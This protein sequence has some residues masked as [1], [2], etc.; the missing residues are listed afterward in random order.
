MEE[1]SVNFQNTFVMDD[2]R[3]TLSSSKGQRSGD[4]IATY[5][6]WVRNHQIDAQFDAKRLWEILWDGVKPETREYL[7]RM[8]SDYSKFKGP[9]SEAACYTEM[10][11]AGK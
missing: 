4:K 3:T 7:R 1:L 9:L 6:T 11:E 5:I 10:L 8:R 2:A